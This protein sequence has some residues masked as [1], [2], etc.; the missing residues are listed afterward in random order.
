M[1]VIELDV[2][3]ILRNLQ[4]IF[5]RGPNYSALSSET[6]MVKGVTENRTRT[7]VTIQSS[8]E[9]FSLA[10]ASCFNGNQTFQIYVWQNVVDIIKNVLN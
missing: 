7:H 9:T 2:K 8:R 3:S 4:F 5:A 1:Q 10:A 6:K